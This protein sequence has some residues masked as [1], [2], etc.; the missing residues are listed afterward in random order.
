MMRCAIMQ[1][2]YLPWLGYFDLI[3]QVDIF[4]LLDNVKLEKSSWHVRNRIRSSQG[5]TVLTIPVILQKS[6][7]ESKIN[8]TRINDSK[9]WRAKHLRTLEQSYS[10]SFYF[11]DFY[12]CLYEALSKETH[13]LSD[14]TSNI[15]RQMALYLGIKTPIYLSSEL[16]NI[17][18]VRDQRLTSICNHFDADTYYSPKGS[19]IYLDKENYGGALTNAG[20]KVIYQDFVPVEYTQSYEPFIP[21][22]SAVDAAFNCYPNEVLNL[23]NQGCLTDWT[24]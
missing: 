4:V 11:N 19:A 20:I 7:L 14:Y 6:R 8:D 5:E 1:P 9:P 10:K 16:N 22:L 3:N 2:T 15:I 17:T 23:I 21:Y 24:K 12:P 13:I 18:G